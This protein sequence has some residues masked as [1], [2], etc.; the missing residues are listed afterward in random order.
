MHPDRL[1]ATRTG[2]WFVVA[3]GLVTV[4]AAIELVNPSYWSPV[5]FLDHAAVIG[6]TVAWLATAWAIFLLSRVPRLGRA[7]WVLI[8][9]AVGTGTSAAGNLFEDL[10]D[11]PLG[12]DMFEWGGVIGAIG[13]LTGSVLALTVK[14]RLRWSGALLLAFLAGGIFPDD[15]G[16]FVSGVALLG[17]GGWLLSGTREAMGVTD[18][19]RT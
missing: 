13:L 6:T 19:A 12:A 5:S 14:D 16:Q 17:L 4:R 11:V 9:A 7:A 3:G 15:G 1:L 18:T 10:L 2:W 8:V